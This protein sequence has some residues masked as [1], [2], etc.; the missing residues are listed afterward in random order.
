MHPHPHQQLVALVLG[1]HAREELFAYQVDGS[2]EVVVA[3]GF[4][5]GD[6][7]FGGVGEGVAHYVAPHSGDVAGV[8]R[9]GAF[10][11]NSHIRGV[12]WMGHSLPFS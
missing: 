2:G 4:G 11:G 10:L 9:H 8:A 6:A 12:R 7:A 3:Q 5:D 1:G